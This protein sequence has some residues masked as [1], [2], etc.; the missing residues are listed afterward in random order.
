MSLCALGEFDC[1]GASEGRLCYREAA[2]SSD[3]AAGDV[4]IGGVV[5]AC[6]PLAAVVDPHPI[7]RGVEIERTGNKRIAVVIG[8][9]R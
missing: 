4:D 7:E 3:G 9:R 2:D 5:L 1:A 6:N 8:D